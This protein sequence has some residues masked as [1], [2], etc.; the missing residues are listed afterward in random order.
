[1]VG[2][3]LNNGIMCLSAF[4]FACKRQPLPFTLF[5][6]TPAANSPSTSQ[7]NMHGMQA[8]TLLCLPGVSLPAAVIA[9]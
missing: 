6:R 8:L 3:P 4:G 1:M 9:G 7:L 5:L 2:L